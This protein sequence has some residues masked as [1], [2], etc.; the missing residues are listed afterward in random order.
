VL[1]L[2]T[3]LFVKFGLDKTQKIL[4]CLNTI[5]VLPAGVFGLSQIMRVLDED[6]LINQVLLKCGKQDQE[7]WKKDTEKLEGT[8]R[9]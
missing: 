2:G 6:K 9:V 5:F 4:S 1:V 3:C 8:Q 7:Q